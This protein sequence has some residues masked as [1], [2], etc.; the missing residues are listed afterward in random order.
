MAR[1]ENKVII[2]TG[3]A[4]GIG[5]ATAKLCA[6]EKAKLVLTDI[7]AEAVAAIAEELA[8]EVI[9][10]AHDVTSET[11]WQKVI[12][13]TLG[14]FGRIDGLVNNAGVLHVGDI[15]STSLEDWQ[16]VMRINGDS[17][18]LGCKSVIPAMKKA[19]GGA[20]VNLSSTSANVGVSSFTAYTASKGLVRTLTKNV[21]AFCIE[22]K[23]N[24]RC[25]S[26]HPKG[27]NT[28]MIT[29]LYDGIDDEALKDQLN[30]RLCLPED[31]GNTIVFL[32]SDDARVANG[33]EFVIDAA[34][35]IHFKG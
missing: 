8:T 35:S 32:L 12:D 15:L 33:A 4:G 27:V 28:R 5:A 26:V 31:I 3:A 11:E 29:S 20:I 7:K 25:N 1:L 22:Q 13:T 17:A 6:K 2:I 10:I 30:S 34:E 23:N 16:R 18:F 21:A 9:S 24:I 19:G 14:R